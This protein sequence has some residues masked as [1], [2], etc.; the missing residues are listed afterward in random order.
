MKRKSGKKGSEVMVDVVYVGDDGRCV[1]ANVEQ[2]FTL[3]VSELYDFSVFE[4]DDDIL[5]G[6]G[7]YDFSGER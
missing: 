3:N 5:Y 1:Q 4:L 6:I 7:G 2:G